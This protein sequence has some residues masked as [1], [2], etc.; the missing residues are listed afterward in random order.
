MTLTCSLGWKPV[1]YDRVGNKCPQD[2]YT[3]EGALCTRAW[4]PQK[5]F[6]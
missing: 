6:L 2:S 5:V 3:P 4:Q 1:V